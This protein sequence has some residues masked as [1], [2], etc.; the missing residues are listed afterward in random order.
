M[1]YTVL[2]IL[3]YTVPAIVVGITAYFII[4]RFVENEQ[5]KMLLQIKESQQSQALKT[6]TP[7]RLQAYERLALFLE[8]M[9]PNNLV[10]RCYQPGMSLKTLQS[11]LVHNIRDEFE[12]NLS[13]Q[14]YVSNQAWDLIRN[15]K[16]EMINL[17]NSSAVRLD[18]DSSPTSLAVAIFESIAKEKTPAETAL[19]FLKDEIHYYFK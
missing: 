1:W 13:Q 12:H 4:K 10:I 7:I 5:K 15:A 2:E 18:A 19:H 3:K 14:I 11:M 17:I 8:R 9:N 16:E 6:I